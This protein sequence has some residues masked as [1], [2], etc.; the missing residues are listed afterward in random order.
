MR[1]LISDLQYEIMRWLAGRRRRW[2][3]ATEIAS[4][5]D[6]AL[7]SF[8]PTLGRLVERGWVEKRKTGEWQYVEIRL[9]ELGAHA[10]DYG[11]RERERC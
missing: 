9:T 10:R 4:V 1:P 6:V 2:L 3:P 11:R 5:A 8:H 7:E